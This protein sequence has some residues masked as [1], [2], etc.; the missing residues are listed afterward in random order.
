MKATNGFKEEVCMKLVKKMIAFVM[1]IAAAVA[2]I[3]IAPEQAKAAAKP[4]IN[5]SSKVIYVGGSSVRPAY[6]ETYT[7]HI[8]N[9]PK[10]YSVTWS[11][12]NEAV[13]KIEKLQYSKA[14]V[15][16]VSAGKATITADFID[17]VSS[18]K[19]TLTTTVTVKK[20]AAA[21]SV[22]PQTIP[23]LDKGQTISLSAT[24]YNKDASEAKAGEITDTVKWTS[25]DPN[26]ATVNASGLVTA[27]KAGKTTITC[28]TVQKTSGTY[29][30]FEKATAKKSVEIEVNDPSVV[31]IISATQASL[32]DIKVVF[33]G[34]YSS[35][36][37]KENLTVKKDGIP[38]LV[39][40]I[41]FAP[42]K[43]EATVSTYYDLVDGST[44]VVSYNNP[45]L[46][47]GQ[48]ASFKATVG[49]PVRMEL[50]TD[51]NRDRVI[52]GKLTTIK[53]RLY[54]GNNVDITPTNVNSSEYY[55]STAR[56]I[57]KQPDTT[58]GM[59]SSWY[60]DNNS[61]SVYLM[62]EGKTVTLTGEYTFL[63]SNG[64]GGL[65][66][67][68]ITAVLTVTSV[69]EAATMLFDGATI[70]ATN[71][72][73][74]NLDWEKPVLKISVSDSKGYKLVARVKGSDGKYM[75]SNETPNIVFGS[76]TSKAC[77]VRD[78]GTITP[79][80]VGSDSVN[81]YYGTD[82]THGVAIGTVNVEVVGKRVPTR[83]V[84]EQN[85]SI[86][87]TIKMSDSYGV[88]DDS[89]N[90]WVY[91]QYNEP[92][93]IT[94]N[95]LSASLPLSTMLVT[96]VNEYGPSASCYAN[97]DK[98]GRIE[99]N[100]AGL[101][102]T[103]GRSFQ[104]KV[105]YN[106]SAYGNLDG[107]ISIIVA[108]PD[109]SATST[110]SV[111]VDGDLN[112]KVSGGITELPKLEIKLYEMKRDL[113]F[114]RIYS[115]KPPQNITGTYITDGDFFYRLYKKDATGVEMK[116]GLTTDYINIVYE[117]N[118]GLVKYDTGEYTLKIFKRVGTVDQI[119]AT[120]D[121]KLTDT[122]GTVK[123]EMVSDTT[124]VPLKNNMTKDELKMVFG[125]C[126]KVMIGT[127]TVGTNQIDFADDTIT[128]NGQV[129]F[130]TFTVTEAVSVNGKT[131]TLSHKV[132][133]NCTIRNKQ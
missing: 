46:T 129:F 96:C 91:D 90:V 100:A 107:Y 11:S 111:E 16:A 5:V 38:L 65:T 34:D 22:S 12:S 67:K 52:A 130:R 93:D 48:S 94:N 61:K 80:D 31:G 101:G 119:K 105:S 88:S 75:Y 40:D 123:W 124:T 58:S 121:F 77:F 71:K 18:T 32:T 99:F 42:N 89:V 33:G 41:T 66:D 72:A 118:N 62:E 14:K 85:G 83:M 131:Y 45:L 109:Q 104:M 39:K 68:T 20:N 79:F 87:Q 116:N 7:F 26:V 44:Y 9:R 69:S 27:I 113:K 54:N 36:I 112:M 28:Y 29:S 97:T 82:I 74:S 81:I 49:E 126:F 110:Y 55:N 125:E 47:E 35:N 17:K 59:Y 8:K 128:N 102:V 1:V 78:D 13:A 30:K 122:A 50:Y 73:G 64:S 4:K 57:L 132:T 76:V 19:Y 84:F 106:D 10:K 56:L 86:V 21:V 120:K 23:R 51:I 103:G 25:S 24:L 6:G 92:I 133:I 37:S 43:M 60:I 98:S 53:F 70:T 95:A 108:T 117:E 63:G 15:T 3:G 2:V 114:S 115:V 127:D